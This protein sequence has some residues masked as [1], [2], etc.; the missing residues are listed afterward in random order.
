MKVNSL[1]K[2][3]SNALR[4][5]IDAHLQILDKKEAEEKG[6]LSIGYGDQ[7]VINSIS[8][9]QSPET[10]VYQLRLERIKK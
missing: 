10:Y 7:Y 2:M 5:Y 1:A 4:D 9:S 6:D 3:K 8:L